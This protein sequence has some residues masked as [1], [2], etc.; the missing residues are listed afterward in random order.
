MKTAF[1]FV[2]LLAAAPVFGQGV[3]SPEVHPDGTVTFRFKASD[4]V[5]QVEVRSEAFPSVKML[6]GEAGMWTYTSAP[7]E[8]DIYSYTFYVNGMQIIDPGNPL[9]KYNLF[10]SSSQVHVPGP[11]TLPWEVN[12]VPHGVVHRHFYRSGIANENRD[13]YVYTP[14]GYDAA[15]KKKYPVLYLLH[16]FT[17]DAS[18]WSTVGCA[19]T[20][21]DNLIAAGKAKPMIV[22]MPIGY[23]TM[24]VLT[25]PRGSEARTRNVE[26]FQ[27]ELLKEIMPMVEKEYRIS[28]DRN[29]RAIAG[30]SMG[31]NEAFHVGL[32]ELDKFSSIC[33]FSAGYD[34][35]DFD[36]Q[37]P[38]L[39]ENSNK[40]IKLLWVGC[41]EQDGL[42]KMN[43][44]FEEWLTEKKVQHIWR[45]MP[46]QH[47]YRVW[48]RNLAEVV[49]LLFQEK[50]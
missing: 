42:M 7:L 47:S 14:P 12:D 39:D 21:L 1:L 5:K 45:S 25:A 19:N 17:D 44:R 33:G 2:L 26:K 30:L 15:A 22:V 31:G 38:R 48:R 23:G 34:R 4:T 36:L 29:S 11:K 28:A 27:D 43:K 3:V 6:E 46:G 50:K 13:Y 37:F 24:D 10:S 35:M 8:P 40:Q 18:A 16:G 41:G 9:L 32:N 49:T 20:I